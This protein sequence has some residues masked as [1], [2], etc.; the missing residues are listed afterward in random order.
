LTIVA[1]VLPTGVDRYLY[2]VAE[3]LPRSWRAPAVGVTTAAVEARRV[4]DLSVISSPLHQ[5]PR[6]GPRLSSLHHDVVA[7]TMSATAVVPLPCRTVVPSDEID[8]WLALHE[9]LLRATLAYVRGRVEMNVRLLHLAWRHDRSLR[10]PG[11]GSLRCVDAGELRHLADRLAEHAGAVEW[12]FRVEGSPPNVAASAAFL[13]PRNET[14]D[15][16]A[17]IGPIASRTPA[18]AI[19]PTGPWA[20]YSFVPAFRA[21]P[22]AGDVARSATV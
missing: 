12:R 21:A 17:R 1:P 22:V 16:L 10:S 19:V 20:P 15:F 8:P 7:T 11:H 5:A 2:A 6:E 4:G 3:R 18:V 9:P 14:G 13:L